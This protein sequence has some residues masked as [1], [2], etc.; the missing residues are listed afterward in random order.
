MPNQTTVSSPYE[1][2]TWPY[3]SPPRKHVIDEYNS[4][5]TNRKSFAGKTAFMRMTSGIKLKK[6]SDDINGIRAVLDPLNSQMER[7]T[8]ASGFKPRGGVTSISIKFR[9]DIGTVRQA[10]VHW[11]TYT[12]KEFDTLSAFFMNPGKSVLL[13]W[14]WADGTISVFTTSEIDVLKESEFEASRRQRIFDSNCNYDAMLGVITNFEW[15]Y[16]EGKYTCITTLLSRGAFFGSLNTNYS[17]VPIPGESGKVASTYPNIHDGFNT[18]LKDETWL[19]T[20]Y[21]KYKNYVYFE[22]SNQKYITWSLFEALLNKFNP[23]NS[24]FSGDVFISCPA[25]KKLD[26]GMVTFFSTEPDIAL[27]NTDGSLKDMEKFVDNQNR[28]LLKNIYLNID[29]LIKTVNECSTLNQLFS[30]LYSQLQSAGNNEWTFRLINRE[31]TSN[32]ISVLESGEA[33]TSFYGIKKADAVA[34][35]VDEKFTYNNINDSILNNG[36]SFDILP[37]NSTVTEISLTSK[38]GSDVVMSMMA[39]AK[40]NFTLLSGFPTFVTIPMG[41]DVTAS[42]DT[43]IDTSKQ[44]I[45]DRIKEQKDA[46]TKRLK[47]ATQTTTKT[48]T[49]VP[50][51]PG[52]PESAIIAQSKIQQMMLISDQGS[53]SVLLPIELNITLFGLSGFYVGN[54]ITADIVPTAYKNNATFQVIGINDTIDSNGWKTELISKFRNIGRKSSTEFPATQETKVEIA[55]A[56]VKDTIALKGNPDDL[57]NTCFGKYIIADMNMNHFGMINDITVDVKKNLIYLCKEFLQPLN[58][59]LVLGNF[60]LSVVSAF[61]SNE[62]NKRYNETV[63]D[64]HTFGSAVDI[65]IRNMSNGK[66]LTPLEAARAINN[67]GLTYD[68]MAIESAWLHV[69]YVNEQAAD[70]KNRKLIYQISF[71][72]TTRNTSI[73][74]VT[75]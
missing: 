30:S 28:G 74:Q 8:Q 71:D 38:M 43:F 25:T 16:D 14:G 32:D 45:D 22:K 59:I 15:S 6:S 58:K 20:Y 55:D 64:L 47:E 69:A 17:S 65:K 66:Y 24:V 41:T 73:T 3:F 42:V 60:Q 63:D 36:I 51:Y 35:T 67:S 18:Y 26:S 48:E 29:N 31:L 39:S 49:Y 12:K 56:S 68:L 53:L 34:T 7:Y 40:S 19:K 27:W 46:E 9:N 52:A 62:V 1:R 50:K 21:T 37:G 33:I 5:I 13:E 23:S 2:L 10:D 61:R 75:L 72:T 4:R 11:S 44:I 70:R 54:V 57:S